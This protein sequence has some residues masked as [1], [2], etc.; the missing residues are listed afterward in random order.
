MS[1]ESSQLREEMKRDLM[2]VYREESRN[3]GGYIQTEAYYRTVHHPAPRFY[4]DARRAHQYIS[5]MLCG[6]RSGL[7]KLKP[8][9]REMYEAL[10]EVVIRL[11][12]KEE[13]CGKS[14]YAI[15]RQAVTEPA[16]RFYVSTARM[17][18]IWLER[19][20]E[21]SMRRKEREDSLRRKREDEK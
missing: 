7:E 19:T 14:L 9:R 21:D 12:R 15:L 18:Q 17:G 10:F 8:L 1:R 13:F 5:P 16:P 4:V 20:R 11:S 3:Y 2:R 6:D